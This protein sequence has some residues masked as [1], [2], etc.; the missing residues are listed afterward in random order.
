MAEIRKT[1]LFADGDSQSYYS[2]EGNSN[3]QIASN[4]G[5]DSNV[6][7][8]SANGRYGQG[9]GFAGTGYIEVSNTLK[10]ANNSTNSLAFWFKTG[11]T[12]QEMMYGEG[13]TA[14]NNPLY[15][16]DIGLTTGKVRLSLRIIAGTSAAVESTSATWND[17]KWHSLV[18]TKN[19]NSF[20]MH[21]DDTQEATLSSSLVPET[22]R[23]GFGALLR[24]T[25]A[26][27]FN[28]EIDDILFSDKVLSAAE[29]TEIFESGYTPRV[30][31]F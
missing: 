19:G 11:G 2:L 22:N 30:T 10:R 13:S 15:N 9:A 7:Y 25:E 27:H 16:I 14:D 1:S 28:G 3:D 31:I 20:V 18:L 12:V 17:D 4:N 29:I 26:I 6:T 8:S 23:V 5:T 21:I 24:A